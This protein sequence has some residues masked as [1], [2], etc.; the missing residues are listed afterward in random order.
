FGEIFGNIKSKALAVS[1]I[2]IENSKREYLHHARY[3]S[4][5][6]LENRKT[7]HFGSTS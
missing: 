2:G 4:D 7:Y 1:S 6:S 3:Q 5:S